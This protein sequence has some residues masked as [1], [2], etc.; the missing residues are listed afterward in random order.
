MI[1]K[2]G[3]VA[4]SEHNINYITRL[5]VRMLP[6]PPQNIHWKLECH[7]IIDWKNLPKFNLSVRILL[8]NVDIVS[9]KIVWSNLPIC[10]AGATKPLFFCRFVGLYIYNTNYRG[11]INIT[12]CKRQTISTSSNRWFCWKEKTTIKMKTTRKT[13]HNLWFVGC[14]YD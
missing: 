5:K 8:V 13:K 10:S 2:D 6:G 4:S 12:D 14:C 1:G 7:T 9:S 3:W 11:V